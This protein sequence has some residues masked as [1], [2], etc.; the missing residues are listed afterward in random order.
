MK[1]DFSRLL[2]ARQPGPLAEIAGVE[3]EDYYALQHEIPINGNWFSGTT[4]MWAERLKPLNNIT[5]PIARYGASNGWLNDQYAITVTIHKQGLVYYVGAYLDENAQLAF[6]DR[7]AE[8]ARIKP[9]ML[10]PQG[11]EACKRVSTEGK[12]ILILINHTTEE[13]VVPLP[14]VA[15][16][17]LM[18][19][20]LEGEVRMAPYG[21]LVLTKSSDG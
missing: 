18:G 17:H 12:D 8:Q 10:T 15:H 20:S 11:V 13:R 5:T 1:D 21:I 19:L 6:M 7:V 4:R 3:V 9:V 16:E 14:W 2:P